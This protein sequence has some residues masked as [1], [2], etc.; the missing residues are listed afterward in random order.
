MNSHIHLILQTPDDQSISISKIMHSICWRFAYFFNRIH[1]RKGHF[2]GSRFKSPIIDT[3]RYSL[4]LL[5]YITQNPVRAGLVKHPKDWLWSSYRVY[6]DG[7]NDPIIDLLPTFEGL[8]AER[9]I[10]ARLFREMVESHIVPKD[11]CWSNSLVIGDK[12]F[13]IDTLSKFGLLAKG[14]PN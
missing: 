10:A 13:V 5:K 8:A 11:R 9:R 14:P 7:V 12:S 2:F 1:N 6:A 4:T 3:E